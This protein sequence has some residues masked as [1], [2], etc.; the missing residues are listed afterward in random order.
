MENLESSRGLV[1]SQRVL[2]AL[3]ERGMSREAAY[4]LVQRNAMNSWDEGKDFRDLDARCDFGIDVK[5][6]IENREEKDSHDHARNEANH[7]EKPTDRRD[8]AGGFGGQFSLLPPAYP[9]DEKPPDA[10]LNEVNL[11]RHGKYEDVYAIPFLTHGGDK[12]RE[13]R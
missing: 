12:Q 6:A 1:F 5:E 13:Y 2:L 4:E 8:D 10:G 11:R 3:I 7:Q 9:M